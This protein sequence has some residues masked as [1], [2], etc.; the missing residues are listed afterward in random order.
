MEFDRWI[1]DW[2]Y[3]SKKS[4]KSFDQFLTVFRNAVVKKV[5]LVN[6]SPRKPTDS[7]KINCPGHNIRMYWTI[8]WH[9][10]VHAQQTIFEKTLMEVDSPHLYGCFGTFCAQI[11]QSLSLWNMFE[12]QQIDVIEGKCRRFRNSSECSKT[13]CATNNWPIM[14]QKVPVFS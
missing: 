10:V 1:L 2:W 4:K 6:L 14:T 12:N 3:F 5:S 11:G 9:P 13:R 7:T 8:F